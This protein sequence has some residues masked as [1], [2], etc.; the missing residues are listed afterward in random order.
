M[1]DTAQEALKF[2]KD[3]NV[4]MVDLK[5]IGLGGQWLHITIPAHQLT[6]KHFE[7]GV[8]YDGSSGS[9]YSSVESGDV[10][11]ACCPVKRRLGVRPDAARVRVAPSGD[12][13][14]DNG[15]HVRE[16]ARPI[17]REVER[18]ANGAAIV[19][20]ELRERRVSR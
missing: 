9:G 7:E 6:E 4:D 8:G 19:D 15:R 16:V 11:R 3:N 14:A 13:Q 12:E 1:F 20:R 5:I 18:R 17:R 10:V 2:E